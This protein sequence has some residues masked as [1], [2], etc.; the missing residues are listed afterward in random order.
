[1]RYLKV[2]FIVILFFVCL[3]FF[4]QN[5]EILT[6][7][8]DIKFQLFKWTWFSST[9]PIYIFILLFFLLGAIISLLYFFVERIRKGKELKDCRAKI[10]S[11]EKELNSLRSTP[12]EQ[13]ELQPAETQD[14]SL[15]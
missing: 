14:N 11:L 3:V 10:S 2:L 7:S 12:L 8:L 4:I 9:V 6:A 13:S 1:M 15:E 5:S